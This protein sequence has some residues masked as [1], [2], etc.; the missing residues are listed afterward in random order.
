MLREN[1]FSKNMLPAVLLQKEKEKSE[2]EKVVESNVK[3]DNDV[4]ICIEKTILYYEK[5]NVLYACMHAK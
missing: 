3:R 2:R 5:A 1:A 4:H